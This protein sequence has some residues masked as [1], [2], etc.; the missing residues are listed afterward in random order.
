MSFTYEFPE[1]DDLL[2]TLSSILIEHD[3]DESRSLAWLL[4]YVEVEFGSFG[5]YSSQR[6]NEYVA[7]MNVYAP[8]K[9]VKFFS[10][11]LK[12]RL[13]DLV[14]ELIPPDCGYWIDSIE[15]IPQLQKAYNNWRDDH[16]K[17]IVGEGL[18]N[19]AN[20]Q[21]SG[22]PMCEYKGIRFRSKSER[23]LVTHF[24]KSGVLFFPLPLAVCGSQIKEPDYLVCKRG[25]WAILEV[26]ADYTHPSVEKEA[27][28]TN[29]FQNHG[30]TIRQYP[31]DECLHS[32][33]EVVANFLSWMD[34]NL[35]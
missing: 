12:T 22:H 10:D 20:F 3:D 27:D 15:V 31:A 26:V 8:M 29:W 14:R 7:Y 32:P 28:R 21:S 6:W 13:L 11:T 30:V 35:A 16:L 4:N 25:R 17:T 23:A 2:Y 33:H 19:Q 34:Q 5:Q 18:N 1:K 24:E 9:L